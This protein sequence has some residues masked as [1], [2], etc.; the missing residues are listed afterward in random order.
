MKQNCSL[1][2]SSK[3]SKSS[4][5]FTA[6]HEWS[7]TTILIAFKA[8]HTIAT[9]HLMILLF[10]KNQIV[11]KC[12]GFVIW[13]HVSNDT[14]R[15]A[16]KH[17]WHSEASGIKLNISFSKEDEHSILSS[18]WK[19]KPIWAFLKVCPWLWKL[20]KISSEKGDWSPLTKLCC[21]TILGLGKSSLHSSLSASTR[22]KWRQALQ[23]R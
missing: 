16:F 5:K 7:F 23:S 18:F 10:F 3:H 20:S 14:Q 11:W 1:L 17:A 2:R 12:I 4:D 9:L 15:L 21:W 22:T 6:R 13:E 19:N 8:I